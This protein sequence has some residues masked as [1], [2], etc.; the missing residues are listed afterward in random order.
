LLTTDPRFAIVTDGRRTAA[1][2]AGSELPWTDSPSLPRVTDA[3]RDATH[4]AEALHEVL[5]AAGRPVELD[6]LVTL[7]AELW[8]VPVT[9]R[10]N[11]ELV[12]TLQSDL[13]DTSARLATRQSLALLWQEI[14][15][16]PADQR[17]ALLLNLRDGQRESAISLFVFTGTADVEELS[18]AVGLTQAKLEEI[19]SELPFEDARIARLLGVSRQQVINL[20]KSARTRLA[21]RKQRG[22]F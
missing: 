6:A 15:A 13:E 12:E 1:A 3:M 18:A 14:R 19:W 11:V 22:G 10:G 21:R 9:P 4:P 20:R 8:D 7:M 16:L 5:A 2:L 17:I